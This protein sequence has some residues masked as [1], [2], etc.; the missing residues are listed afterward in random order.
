MQN[1]WV[2]LD[3]DQEGEIYTKDNFLALKWYF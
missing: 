3:V 2:Y 1:I